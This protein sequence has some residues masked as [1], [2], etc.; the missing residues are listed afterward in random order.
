FQLRVN[1]YR[2]LLTRGRDACV[3][4]APPIAEMDETFAYLAA[5]GFRQ[6]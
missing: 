6:L 4:F 5:A 3:V 2:V 1:A